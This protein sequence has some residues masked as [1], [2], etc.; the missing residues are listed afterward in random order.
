MALRK[1]GIGVDIERLVLEGLPIAPADG[2]LVQSAVEAELARLLSEG[3]LGQELAAGGTVPS[4]SVVGIRLEGGGPGE[5][6]RQIARSVY[7]GM[8]R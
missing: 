5:M 4:V 8:S 7:G 2:P 6:G 1:P 3:G